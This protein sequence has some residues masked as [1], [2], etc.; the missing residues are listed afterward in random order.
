MVDNTVPVKEVYI[1]KTGFIPCYLQLKNILKEQINS[2]V[3]I[4]TIPSEREL[5]EKF[6]LSRSTVRQTINEMAKEGLIVKRRGQATVIIPINRMVRDYA[7]ELI[8]FSE[9]MRRKGLIPSSKVLRFEKVPATTDL[10]EKLKVKEGDELVLLERI[11]YGNTEPF[12][13]GISYLPFSL[14]PTIFQFDFNQESLHHI[15]KSHYGLDLVMSQ[16]SFE[17]A[18]PSQHEAQLLG[19]PLC[20]SLLLMEG[21]TYAADG[22]PVEY[23]RLKFRGDKARFTVKVFKNRDI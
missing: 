23:F 4:A 7:H 19:I 5:S 13:L 2:G 20:S 3:F 15:L 8:S 1:S 12:N 16:E 18:M 17:P 21:L 22:T 14:C 6:H 9:E 11:R 10:A